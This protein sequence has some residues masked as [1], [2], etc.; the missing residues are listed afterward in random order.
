MLAE[1]LYN[2]NLFI[3]GIGFNGI[4][5]QVTPPSIKYKIDD[6]QGGGMDAPVK[7]PLGMEA[8]EANFSIMGNIPEALKCVGIL[9]QTVVFRAAFRKQNGD[10]VQCIITL[11][12]IIH[13]LEPGDWRPGDK[14]ENKFTMGCDYY[15]MEIEGYV[16]YEADPRNMVWNVNGHDTLEEFRMALG[17]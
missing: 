3:D 7:V 4:V 15:K 11:T 9:N 5:T 10:A 13:M 6:F 8:L 16:M 14:G 12:G 1:S 2:I 17:I